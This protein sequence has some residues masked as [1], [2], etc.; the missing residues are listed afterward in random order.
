MWVE[1]GVRG[2][3]RGEGEAA[4]VLREEG[5]AF[6]GL[7]S[8]WCSRVLGWSSRVFRLV[9]R[10]LGAQGFQVQGFKGQVQALS[11]AVFR[12]KAAQNMRQK[13]PKKGHSGTEKMN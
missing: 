1:G 6:K 5:E 11:W 7:V 3:G 9:E 10:F 2:G 13:S 8:R 4:S 12:S